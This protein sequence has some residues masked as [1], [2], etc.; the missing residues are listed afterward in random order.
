[1]SANEVKE[2]GEVPS[3]ECVKRVLTVNSRRRVRQQS[4]VRAAAAFLVH[5]LVSWVLCWVILSHS[6]DLSEYQIESGWI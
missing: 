1:M 2:E 4:G 3:V 6:W 5:L